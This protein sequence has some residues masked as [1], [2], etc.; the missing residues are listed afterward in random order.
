MLSPPSKE[1]L[2]IQTYSVSP[3][4]EQ[5]QVANISKVD[6]AVAFLL[7]NEGKYQPLTE[8]EE[9]WAVKKTDFILLPC[10]FWTATMGAVSSAFLLIFFS[11]ILN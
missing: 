6:D 8:A 2:E 10:L 7:E 9:R 11:E 1:N 3:E 5:K 4:D